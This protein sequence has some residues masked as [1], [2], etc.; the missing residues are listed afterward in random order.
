MYIHVYIQVKEEK[1]LVHTVVDGCRNTI[2]IRL[3]RSVCIFWRSS[4]T[5][6][7]T[8]SGRALAGAHRITPHN[9]SSPLYLPL[10][11]YLLVEQPPPQYAKRLDWVRGHDMPREQ[12][13]S[14]TWSAV[15]TR[16][17]SCYIRVFA[18][19][20]L[21]CISTHT[22]AGSSRGASPAAHCCKKQA[23]HAAFLLSPLLWS[24]HSTRSV[25]RHTH[26]QQEKYE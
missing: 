18:C 24:T 11:A 21:T 8:C 10:S 5:R 3:L 17:R 20:A 26:T 1:R 22:S 19:V 23:S 4:T 12:H 14:L 25:S 16:C 13:A 9:L 7:S 15:D 6:M 2:Y